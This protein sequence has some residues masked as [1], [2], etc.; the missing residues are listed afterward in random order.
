MTKPKGSTRTHKIPPTGPG[1]SRLTSFTA[2][3]K[4]VQRFDNSIRRANRQEMVVVRGDRDNFDRPVSKKKKRGS[5][6]PERLARGARQTMEHFGNQVPVLHPRLLKW[7]TLLSKPFNSPLARCPVNYN[8]APSLLTTIATV[9]S[10]NSI[11]ALN[12]SVVEIGIWPGHNETAV[13]DEMDGRAYHSPL[14]IIGGAAQ[15]FSIG[16]IDNGVVE[17]CIG[18]Y[19]TGLALGNGTT[20]TNIAAVTPILENTN[21]PYK[22]VHGTG[23]HSRWKLVSCGIRLQN[24]TPLAARGGSITWCQ[25]ASPADYSQINQY[26][27]EPS[28]AITQAAN[29]GTLEISWVPRTSDLAFWHSLPGNLETPVIS[30]SEVGLRIWIT[31]P[32]VD[33]QFYTWEIIQHYELAGHSLVAVCSPAINQPADKNVVE[34]VASALHLVG[35]GAKHA[36]GLAGRIAAA[37]GPFLKELPKLSVLAGV[38]KTVAELF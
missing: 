22:T 20:S 3:Q 25:P 7:F 37:S 2:D 5:A 26:S 4:A 9:T 6:M 13:T 24:V 8:P 17:N 1:P 30:S 10:T 34:P 11:V 33:T 36:V 32:A 14:Q 31:A 16:P 28:F 19:Q 35:E 29:T 18:Y 15:T 12:D 23:A 27:Q 21:L 38:A